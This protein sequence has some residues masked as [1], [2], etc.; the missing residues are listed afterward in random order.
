MWYPPTEI[1]PPANE[2]LTLEQ[3]KAHL[4]VFHTDD[5]DYIGSLIAASR[6][7][8]ERYCGAYWADRSVVIYA[9]SFND[10]S[11]FP[12]AQVKTIG[13]IEYVDNDGNDTQLDSAI[14]EFQPDASRF[15]L[16]F[17]QSWPVFRYGSRIKVT[18]AVGGDV[19]APVIHAIKFK[20]GDMYELRESAS[21][22]DV[23][24]FDH[25]LANYRYYGAA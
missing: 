22:V 23:T 6:Q 25:I 12:I 3:A 5:D 21:D 11:H 19:P 16:K 17:G 7:A 13:A 15:I 18:A 20:I 9:D 8:C 14:Y 1:A 4:R 2:P 10:L 24:T